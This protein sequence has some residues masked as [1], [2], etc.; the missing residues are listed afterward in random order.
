GEEGV[1]IEGRGH[2][3][4]SWGRTCRAGAGC[5][6][7][8]GRGRL[9]S[10]ASQQVGVERRTAGVS[11]VTTI[12]S[13]FPRGRG[14]PRRPSFTI[15]PTLKRAGAPARANTSRGSLTPER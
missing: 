11:A 15:E 10:G 4:G 7:P 3:R 14:R 5:R 1:P 13:S 9:G 12:R 8:A 6:E 2:L